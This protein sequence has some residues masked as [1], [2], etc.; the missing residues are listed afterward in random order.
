MPT[1]HLGTDVFRVQFRTAQAGLD[2]TLDLIESV[3]G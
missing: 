1:S 2:G 3:I